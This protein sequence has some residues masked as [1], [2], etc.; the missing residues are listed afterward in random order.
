MGILGYDFMMKHNATLN[1]QDNTLLIKGITV[2]LIKHDLNQKNQI[3]VTQS[4]ILTNHN[5]LNSTVYISSKI[6][7]DENSI[8]SVEVQVPSKFKDNFLFEPISINNCELFASIHTPSDN[9][10]D[11]NTTKFLIYIHNKSHDTIHLNQ[12]QVVGNIATIDYIDYTNIAQEEDNTD[13]FCNLIQASQEVLQMRKDQL[14]P[15]DFNLEHLQ[16]HEQKLMLQVLME[17][18]S[19]FSKS[20]NTLGHTDKVKPHLSFLHKYPIK[21]LPFPIPQALHQ[22]AKQQLAELEAAGI[23]ERANTEWACPM[24]FVKKKPIANEKPRFR[25][26]LDLRLINSIIKSSSYPLPKIND[27]ISNLSSFKFFTVM[28]LSNAYWQI[29]IGRAHV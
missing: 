17:N 14:T 23:I 27:I 19:A 8:S 26:A 28:D 20:L 13:H 9:S 18:Y 12:G 2:P 24:L 11:N 10:N 3:N 25:M 5:S 4:D 29:E 21:C 15:Q 6:N 7:L 1:L 22:E 16:E